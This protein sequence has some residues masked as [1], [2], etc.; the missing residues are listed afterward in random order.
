MLVYRRVFVGEI[1]N[2]LQV[3]TGLREQLGEKHLDTLTGD[4]FGGNGCGTASIFSMKT[5]R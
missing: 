2:G 5:V 3:L 4:P 1:P